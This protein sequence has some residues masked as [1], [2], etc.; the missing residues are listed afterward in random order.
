L[1][2]GALGKIATAT[3][4]FA[5]GFISVVLI[6]TCIAF[7]LMHSGCKDAPAEEDEV[8][9][10]FNA[11]LDAEK[12]AGLDS[13]VLHFQEYLSAE[14][15]EH[16]TLESRTEAYLRRLYNQMER[17][18][19]IAPIPEQ[20]AERILSALENS[21][22]RRELVLCDGEQYQPDPSIQSFF[23]QLEQSLSQSLEPS[24]VLDMIVLGEEM[25]ENSLVSDISDWELA[26]QR[27]NFHLVHNGLYQ[28]ALTKA[29]WN[30]PICHG[31]LEAMV[32]A[33]D[34]AP[35]LVIGGILERNMNEKLIHPI[36]QRIIATEIF[37]GQIDW[38]SYCQDRFP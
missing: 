18:D 20:T 34:I 10:E 26:P 8:M 32:L 7:G 4:G 12:A 14:F 9:K 29:F 22:L 28:Y 31:Y 16:K 17:Q 30:V 3:H 5:S 38:G 21:G 33:G 19:A 11:I 13:L 15:P 24:G 25:G 23:E 2:K 35:S 37:L 36:W 1:E 27:N 6:S